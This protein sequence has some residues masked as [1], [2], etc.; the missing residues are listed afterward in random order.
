MPP[1]NH[2]GEL[3]NLLLKRLA[4]D[5]DPLQKMRRQSLHPW[6]RC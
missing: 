5:K 4:S 6:E 3:G 1:A 2:R